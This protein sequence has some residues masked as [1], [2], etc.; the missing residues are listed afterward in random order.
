MVWRATA[1]LTVP[2]GAFDQASQLLHLSCNLFL[3][4]CTA[5]APTGALIRAHLLLAQRRLL[6]WLSHHGM[7]CILKHPVLG[8]VLWSSWLQ[9][10]VCSLAVGVVGVIGVMVVDGCLEQVM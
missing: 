6:K 2:N 4:A 9:Y 1:I 10:G 5:S 8:W 3:S 7:Q